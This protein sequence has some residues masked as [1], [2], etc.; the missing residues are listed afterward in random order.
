MKAMSAA[1]GKGK[2]KEENKGKTNKQLKA[3]KFFDKQRTQAANKK[4]SS[5]ASTSRNW[6]G[7]EVGRHQVKPPRLSSRP[8]P[9]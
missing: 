5:G 8:S 7:L 2:G 3:E 4:W 1:K 6:Q 9:L